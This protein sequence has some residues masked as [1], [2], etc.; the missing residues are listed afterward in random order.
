M[1][2]MVDKPLFR[3][4]FQPYLPFLGGMES[5]IGGVGN[6]LAVHLAALN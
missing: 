6:A 1:V 3:A 4:P 5:A 2:E